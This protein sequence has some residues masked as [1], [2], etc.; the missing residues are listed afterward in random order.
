MRRIAFVG[1]LAVA[2]C[3]TTIHRKE[4]GQTKSWEVAAA[5]KL[6]NLT[7]TAS[8]CEKTKNADLLVVCTARTEKECETIGNHDVSAFCDYDCSKIKTDGY[9]ELC[10]FQG[11][12]KT[13]T[14][15][16][17]YGEWFAICESGLPSKAHSDGCDAGYHRNE[18]TRDCEPG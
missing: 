3:T 5:A 18:T 9:R 13:C 1:V 4:G 6:L 12:L 8:Q 2:A 17:K 10:G 15:M 14:G 7:G 11:H 16:E